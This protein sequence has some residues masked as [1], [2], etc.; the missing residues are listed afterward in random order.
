[1]PIIIEAPAISFINF[2]D[3]NIDWANIQNISTLSGEAFCNTKSEA[4]TVARSIVAREFSFTGIPKYSKV[5]GIVVKVRRRQSD[6]NTTRDDTVRLIV[7]DTI[8]GANKASSVNWETTDTEVVYGSPTDIW[9]LTQEQ[10][11]TIFNQDYSISPA[12]GVI[13]RPVTDTSSKSSIGRSDLYVSYI[14]ITLYLKVNECYKRVNG[15]WVLSKPDIRVGNSYSPTECYV[16]K[17]NQWVALHI[18]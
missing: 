1:M 12:F 16:R 13:F 14:T 10:L 18:E 9:G 11:N 7:N 15:Q 5:V 3:G 2:G 4:N 17:N 6:N 8:V